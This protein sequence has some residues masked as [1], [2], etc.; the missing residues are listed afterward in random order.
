MRLQIIEAIKNTFGLSK[1][2]DIARLNSNGEVTK[3]DRLVDLIKLLLDDGYPQKVIAMAL[4]DVVL[5]IKLKDM[6]TEK[7]VALLE[8]IKQLVYKPMDD[9]SSSIDDEPAYRGAVNFT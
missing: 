5:H 9:P 7:E 6:R 8:Q 3:I 2:D 1:S 4:E